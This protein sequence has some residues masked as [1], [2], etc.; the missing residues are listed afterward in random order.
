MIQSQESMIAVALALPILL[1]IAYALSMVARWLLRGRVRL[2]AA[3]ATVLAVIGISGGLL[4]GA[5]IFRRAQLWSPGVLLVALGLTVALL[6]GFATIAS[7]LQPPN[8]IT[9]INELIQSGESDR[10]E[11]KSTARWNLHT[12]S[13][14]ERME[15]VISKAVAGFLNADGGTLL[16]GVDDAGEIVGLIPDFQIVKSPDPDRFELWLRDHLAKTLGQNA[17]SLPVVDF[18]AVEV[19]QQPTFV[20]RVACPPS[21]RPIYLRAM[22]GPAQT[23]FWVRNGNSTRQ[24][25]LDEAVEYVMHRWPLGVGSSLAAQFRAAARGTGAMT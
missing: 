6:A 14:D 9:P 16:I 17:S 18:T 24:L 8:P 11:F 12:K 23:E 10:L 1:L 5:L 21:P 25:K 15:Q 2:S 20:C 7:R 4:I 22:K 19:D 13:R 3:T